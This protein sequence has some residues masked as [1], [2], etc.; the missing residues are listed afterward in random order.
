MNLLYN[1]IGDA[2]KQGFTG[3]N[4]DF[5]DTNSGAIFDKPNGIFMPIANYKA[6]GAQR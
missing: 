1:K 3:D 5:F 6:Y 4:V 2:P